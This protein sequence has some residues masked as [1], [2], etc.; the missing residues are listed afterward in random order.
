MTN[1]TFCTI[2]LQSKSY[3][4]KCPDEEIDN[5]HLAA[6]KLNE[7]LTSNKNKFKRLD[8][9]QAL[10]MTALH[11]S[12]ELVTCQRQQTQQQQEFAEFFKAMD[13]KKKS[14]PVSA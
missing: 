6:Q 9:Y 3:K 4:I 10:I 7:A 12:H 1:T 2:Q 14:T 11:L 13:G 5:L 8:D